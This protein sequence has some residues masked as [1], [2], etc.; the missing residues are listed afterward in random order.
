MIKQWLL[1]IKELIRRTFMG[2]PR[3]DANE[4]N[5]LNFKE[6][7]MELPG[8]ETEDESVGNKVEQPVVYEGFL[9]GILVKDGQFYVAQ[10]EATIDGKLGNFKLITDEKNEGSELARERFTLLA[11]QKILSYRGNQDEK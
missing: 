1:Y 8:V 7:Q 11:S 6:Q 10:A 9:L 2:R 3:K 4:S 5:T